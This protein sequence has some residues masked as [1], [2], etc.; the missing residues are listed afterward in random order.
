MVEGHHHHRWTF[1]TAHLLST[2]DFLPLLALPA[3]SGEVLEVGSRHPISAGLEG[4]GEVEEE[5]GEDSDPTSEEEGDFVVEEEILVAVAAA[6]VVVG[7]VGD[8]NQRTQ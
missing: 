8:E 3:V 4:E 6:V 7:G 1:I 2:G 5:E